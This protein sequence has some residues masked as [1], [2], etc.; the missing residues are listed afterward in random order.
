MSVICRGKSVYSCSIYQSGHVC[1]TNI[2]SREEGV[3]YMSVN[4]ERLEGE[5]E[6]IENSR[7]GED[8]TTVSISI[9]DAKTKKVSGCCQCWE[10]MVLC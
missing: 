5:N 3:C 1:Y 2:T 10:L 8:K 7:N 6:G 4:A 9:S